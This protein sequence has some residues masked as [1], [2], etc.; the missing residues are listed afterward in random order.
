MSDKE[1]IQQLL[2]GFSVL[3][4]EIVFLKQ[5]IVLLK[6]K[7]EKYEN[8]K[9]SKNSSI[10]PSQDPNRETKSLR[11]KSG[12]KVG[13]QKGHKGSKLNKVSTP[14]KIILHNI[15]ECKCC[16]AQLPEEGEVNHVKYL[17]LLR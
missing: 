1:L 16:E 4:E 12:K 11:K 5:E 8:P 15:T 13:G 3:Q 17:I 7:L 14:D 6:E 9:D 2:Q 10:P